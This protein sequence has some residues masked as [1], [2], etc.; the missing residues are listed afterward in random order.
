MSDRGHTDPASQYVDRLAGYDQRLQMLERSH[1]HEPSTPVGIMMDWPGANAPNLWH[2]A[3]GSSLLVAAYPDLFAVLGY[4]YGGSGA[5]FN[6][7]NTID[8]MSVTVGQR[9]LGSVGG[10]QTVALTEANLAPHT[11]TFGGTTDTTGGQHQHSGTTD[12]TGGQ[13]QHSGTTGNDSP[14]H[15]HQYYT[16]GGVVAAAGSGAYANNSSST[17]AGATVRHA[18]GFTTDVQGAHGH[19][20]NTTAAGAHGHPFNGTTGSDGS[21]TAHENMPPWVALNKIIKVL[22]STAA[23]L[24]ALTIIERSP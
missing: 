1:T 16:L 22:P 8:R 21:G 7:P 24:T 15:A 6:L 5:N 11:H 17:T 3:D 18:H 19:P 23:S 20:F 4:R 14:D 2:F 9:S 12:T 10:Q 13:H